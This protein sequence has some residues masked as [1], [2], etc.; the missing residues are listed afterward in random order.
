[1]G[2][3]FL[4]YLFRTEGTTGKMGLLPFNIEQIWMGMTF[5][6]N[7]KR[8]FFYFHSQGMAVELPGEKM[9]LTKPGGGKKWLNQLFSKK[10]FTLF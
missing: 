6:K 3:M 7:G 1:M 5:P 10:P 9:D 2:S 8:G 4:F